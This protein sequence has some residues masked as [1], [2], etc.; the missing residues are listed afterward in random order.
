LFHHADGNRDKIWVLPLV[1]D[2]GERKPRPL[3]DAKSEERTAVFSPDGHW[4]AYESNQSGGVEV[5]VQPFPGPGPREQISTEQGESPVWSRNGREL[6]YVSRNKLMAVTITTKPALTA[7][8]PQQLF[9]ADGISQGRFGYDVDPDGKHFLTIK[10]EQDL[11]ATQI[12]VVVNWFEEL[13]RR[14]K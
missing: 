9:E 10:S 14:V 11:Y 1:T 2:N 4:V 13:K 3:I 5:Y 12:N 7:S 6:F 8:K